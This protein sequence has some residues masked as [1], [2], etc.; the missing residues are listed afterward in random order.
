ML[1]SSLLN[2]PDNSC[3]VEEA[4]QDLRESNLP[5]ELF[6]LYAKKGKH[7]EALELLKEQAHLDGSPL[8]GFDHTVEYLQGLNEE[9]LP[10]V[11]EYSKWV[12]G[13]I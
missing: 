5:Y 8:Q 12:L 4:E 9:H 1:I 6:L 10:L 13:N 3:I 7:K 11:F 2:L